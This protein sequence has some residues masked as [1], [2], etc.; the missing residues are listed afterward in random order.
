[1]N[2]DGI[3]VLT[4]DTSETLRILF[5]IIGIIFIAFGVG[6]ICYGFA[7][8]WFVQR[9]IMEGIFV[10]DRFSQPFIVAFGICVSILALVVIFVRIK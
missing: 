7:R 2:D 1:M 4:K 8:Y 3:I 9:K 5:T 6:I 10:K